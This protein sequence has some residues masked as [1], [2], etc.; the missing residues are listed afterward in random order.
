MT[1]K[2]K[3]TGDGYEYV[4]ERKTDRPAYIHRLLYVAEH[5][6]DAL[7]PTDDVHHKIPIP[8]LNTPDNLVAQP[9]PVHRSWNLPTVGDD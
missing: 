8:W 2:L 6:F 5:G 3:M 7:K 1:L 4:S 9:A